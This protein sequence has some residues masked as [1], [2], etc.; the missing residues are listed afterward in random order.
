MNSN[1]LYDII[2]PKLKLGYTDKIKLISDEGLETV[3]K[4]DDVVS[5]DGD[6]VLIINHKNEQ[7]EI[8]LKP[9]SINKIKIY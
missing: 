8:I 3:I 2:A 5:V 4:S 6:D 7:T 1:Q 9:E